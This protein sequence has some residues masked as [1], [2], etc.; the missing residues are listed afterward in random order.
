MK[1]SACMAAFL[2]FAG[3]GAYAAQSSCVECHTNS[4]TIQSL[5]VPP[6]AGA[7]EA[8]EG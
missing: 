2:V 1:R 6:V 8:G 5:F 7:A 3:A 4:K